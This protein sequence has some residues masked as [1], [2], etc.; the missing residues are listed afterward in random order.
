MLNG[1]KIAIFGAGGLLGRQLCKDILTSG[2]K[3]LAIDKDISSLPASLSEIGVD[4]NT[5]SLE[6][7]QLDICSED[8]MMNFFE[9]VVGVDGA[10]NTVYPRNKTYGAK[11]EDVSLASFNE[12]ISLN[13]GAAF[14][15][16]KMFAHYYKSNKAP[17]S[18]VN[19]SS[20][21]G[22]V[23]PDFS[24]YDETNMTMPVEYAAIKSA[25]LHMS[26]YVSAYVGESDFRV[27]N[28]SPG[29]LLDSQPERFLNSYRKKT[30][31]AGMLDVAD[32]SGSVIFLLSDQSRYVNGQNIVVDDGFSF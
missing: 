22:T 23:A 12:N 17:I 31:G 29:G 10:V 13:L 28:V 18:I 19:I 3:V 6:L 4:V 15:L 8:Q 27:N 9:G 14:L 2:G 1:K 26:K 30:F 7:V 21:Y 20:I 24:I 11:F 16:M 32:I 5:K 25:L